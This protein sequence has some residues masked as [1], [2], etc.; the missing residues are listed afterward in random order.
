M[1]Y[2]A[3]GEKPRGELEL[4]ATS[5]V[6]ALS[7][8]EPTGFQVI[9]AGGKALKVKA[10][11]PAECDAWKSALRDVIHSVSDL[12]A[13]VCPKTDEVRADISCGGHLRG[14]C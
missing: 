6:G 7:S 13:T 5:T 8:G 1:Y 12:N 9:F 11:T 2:N 3:K 10:A 4:N 14:R